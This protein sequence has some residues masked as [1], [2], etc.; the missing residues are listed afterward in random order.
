MPYKDLKHKVGLEHHGIRNVDE[1]FWNL[2]N[3][4]ARKISGG[5][6]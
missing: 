2:S 4:P 3:R 1:I 5:A 6:R